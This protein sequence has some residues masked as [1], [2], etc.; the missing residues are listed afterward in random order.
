LSVSR[1]ISSYELYNLTA[2]E[3]ALVEAATAPV[4]KPE[5]P[6][7]A[8]TGARAKRSQKK[9]KFWDGEA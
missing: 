9:S 2:E 8:D 1:S 3:I 6:E 5:E 4:E 7:A